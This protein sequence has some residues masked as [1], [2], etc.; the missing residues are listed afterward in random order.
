MS[1][2]NDGIMLERASLVKNSNTGTTTVS[3]PKAKYTVSLLGSSHEATELTVDVTDTIQFNW[4]ITGADIVQSSYS[5]DRADQCPDPGSI[6]PVPLDPTVISGVKTQQIKTCQQGR[7][8][9]YLFTAVD[10]HSGDTDTAEILIHVN[11]VP[12]FD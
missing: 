6:G 5:S 11:S 12:G 10:S 1:C 2:T 3:T 8:Y 9:M 4:S 7:T